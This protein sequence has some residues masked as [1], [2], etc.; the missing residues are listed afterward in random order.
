LDYGVSEAR[1]HGHNTIFAIE[2]IF[3]QVIC[4]DELV[5]LLLQIVVLEGQ[6]VGMVLQGMQ[7]LFET[8]TGFEQ[9]LIA[10]PDGVKFATKTAK[11][12]LTSDKF[13]VTC[14]QISIQFI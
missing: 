13:G 10:S 4:E 11:F 8:V 2:A 9:L 12:S 5:E 14:A 6:N 1:F 3:D 7:F